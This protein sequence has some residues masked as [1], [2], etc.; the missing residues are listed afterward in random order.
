MVIMQSS[1]A[2]MAPTLAALYGSAISLEQA[3]VLAI[4][5][6]IGK[7]ATALMPSLSSTLSAYRTALAHIVFNLITAIVALLLVPLFTSIMQILRDVH[8]WEP[9]T[10]LVS[11]HPAFNFPGVILLM[12]MIAPITTLT[13][14]LLSDNQLRLPVTSMRV[15]FGFT[16]WG[17]RQTAR[18]D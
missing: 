4:G 12:P 18:P 13:F 8:L 5:Q 10:I 15:K 14:H 17:L 9:T 3:A 1:S 16:P 2:A 11:F 7:T 6:N